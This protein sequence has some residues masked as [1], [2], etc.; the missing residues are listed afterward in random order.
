VSEQSPSSAGKGRPTPKR[1][2]AQRARGGPVTPPPTNRREA[3]KQL[4]ERQAA[5][6]TRTRKANLGGGDDSALMARDRGP[7]R[8]LV[9][10]VID[11]RRS[12]GW[13]LLPVALAVVIA[14]LLQNIQVQ[15]M[16]FGLFLATLLGALVDFVLIGFLLRGRIREQFP[17]E[18]RLRA[19]LGYGMLRSTVIRR[20]RMPR[21]QVQRGQR[22]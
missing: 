17:Q 14:G 1:R 10:D 19:H 4:R 9:R 7:V 8:R 21:P 3:A 5:D 16:A 6:R 18:G 13:V 2:D 11:S 22:V 20:M 15:A 12:V